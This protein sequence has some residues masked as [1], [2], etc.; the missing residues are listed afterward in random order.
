MQD[1]TPIYTAG[2]VKEWFKNNNIL[3]IEW[4]LYSSDLNLIKII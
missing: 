2:K 4:P 3:I 1:N